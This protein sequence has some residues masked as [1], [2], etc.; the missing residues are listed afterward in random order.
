M[1]VPRSAN[2]G[3]NG[4]GVDQKWS[5][6]QRIGAKFDQDQIS[7][8]FDQTWPGIFRC[9]PKLAGERPNL[10]RD[11]PKLTRIRAKWGHTGRRNDI[12]LGALSEQCS[13]LGMCRRLAL[14][15]LYRRPQRGVGKTGPRSNQGS[16]NCVAMIGL[17]PLG[18]ERESVPQALL[19]ATEPHF[20]C[21]V[22]PDSDARSISSS[23]SR[24]NAAVFSGDPL[25]TWGLCFRPPSSTS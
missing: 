23:C 17:A 19:D 9:R 6:C 12:H 10:A 7:P 8:E 21:W 13:V 5:D 2:I 25:R 1:F 16:P 24:P 20:A 22:D 18:F 14:G 15:P 3:R 4:P 11:R